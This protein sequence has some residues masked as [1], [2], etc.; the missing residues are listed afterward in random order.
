VR[1]ILVAL[2]TRS[3]HGVHGAADYVDA[4]H[5]VLHG[6]QPADGARLLLVE[7]GLRAAEDGCWRYDLIYSS[8]CPAIPRLD[9]DNDEPGPAL[10][11]VT[12][13]DDV[14]GTTEVQ[15]TTP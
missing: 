10:K 3:L 11:R 13:P 8:S 12:L 6:F 4:V 14:G 15:S 7:D 5:E 2:Y 1:R 9:S